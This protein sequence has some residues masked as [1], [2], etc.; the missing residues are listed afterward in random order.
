MAVITNGG[1]LGYV[2]EVSYGSCKVAGLTD[3]SSAIGVYCSRSGVYGTAEGSESYISDGLL[4]VSGLS[5]DSN[6]R[7]GD[8]FCTSGYGGI[9]PADFPV[10]RVKSV[11]EDEF[12]RNL[13]VVL[14]PCA[15]I[16]NAT[17]VFVVI[18]TDI[19]TQG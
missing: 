9:F 6:V 14:E 3:V 2:K 15:D 10:G 16:L 11:K 12:L 17:R 8:L 7:I 5:K 18:S 1:V 13:T 4:V 19:K